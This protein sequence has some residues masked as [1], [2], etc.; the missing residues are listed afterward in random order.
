MSQKEI[1]IVFAIRDIMTRWFG[2]NH[3]TE[4]PSFIVS[5]ATN[6][7]QISCGSEHTT[8]LNLITGKVYVCG[9]NKYKQV[10]FDDT[11]CSSKLKEVL[12]PNKIR[13]ISCSNASNIAYSDHVSYMWGNNNKLV[14]SAQHCMIAC[15][16]FCK[17]VLDTNGCI[18]SID[19]SGNDRLIELVDVDQIKAGLF[20]MIAL[21]KSGHVYSWGS[22]VHGQL[23]LGDREGRND[24]QKIPLSKI[25]SV[26]C[27]WHHTLALDTDGNVWG[28]GINY[29][30]QIQLRTDAVE[31]SVLLPRKIAVEHIISMACSANCSIVIDQN[32]DLWGWGYD[33]YGQ[34][35]LG[36]S[37]FSWNP[38]KLDLSLAKY[39]AMGMYH[40]IAVTR[41]DECYVWGSNESGQL[42]LG[43]KQEQFVPHKLSL[44][45]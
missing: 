12:L 9:S 18:Y 30:G 6:H 24:P 27:G 39:I 37:T 15:A 33:C 22:N 7:I 13:S 8:I 43:D 17:L 21:T 31:G 32:G 14:T 45:F 10:C 29:Q 20:H 2:S 19:L 35:G 16:E 28:W 25:M 40:T 1:F 3:P 26:C 5:F 38:C 44:D 41:D 36:G 11:V 23:G 4:I 34:F 42:G